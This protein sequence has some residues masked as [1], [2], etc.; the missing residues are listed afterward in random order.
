MSFAVVSMAT[1]EMRELRDISFPNKQAYCQRHGYKWIGETKTRDASRPP[2]WSKILILADLCM[3][4]SVDWAFWTDAD[5]VIVRPDW[6]LETLAD[7]SADLVVARDINGI[8]MGVF[9]MRMGG[10]T[11]QFLL[12][13]Y[14]LTQYIHHRWWDQAAI[15]HALSTGWPFRAKYADK[16]LINAYP[17][18][19]SEGHS[20]IV[21]VPKTSRWPDRVGELRKHLP[22]EF[23]VNPAA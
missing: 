7:E 11:L 17:D 22:Q 9:L 16:T 10:M 5:S 18:D 4:R 3:N 14:S 2:S 1:D 8:N 12:D 20:A 23:V 21:H 19:F 13:A 15:R 6:K